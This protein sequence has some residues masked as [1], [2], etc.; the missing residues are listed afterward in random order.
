[1]LTSGPPEDRDE[2]LVRYLPRAQHRLDTQWPLKNRAQN[3]NKPNMLD[4]TLKKTLSCRQYLLYRSPN[5][6][7]SYKTQ[8]GGHLLQEAIPRRL[9]E[10]PS[11]EEEKFPRVS[12]VTAL[13]S[14]Y[15]TWG[16]PGPRGERLMRATPKGAEQRTGSCLSWALHTVAPRTRPG[17]RALPSATV[18]FRS[19]TAV[20]GSSE[21]PLSA[22][23]SPELHAPSQP[24]G[25][26]R[27]TGLLPVF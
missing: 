15:C 12:F 3:R 19:H 22:R 11:P 9:K 8:P 23:P 2:A 21:G 10:A 25:H 1:M 27:A 24:S 4:L 7:S 16:P 18:M 20:P 17:A 5:S 26:R 14:S 13:S 6:N